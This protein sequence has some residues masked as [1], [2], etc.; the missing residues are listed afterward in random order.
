MTKWNSLT[1]HEQRLM[2]RL[3]GEGSTRNQDP[4]VIAGLRDLGLIEANGLSPSGYDLCKLLELTMVSRRSTTVQAA[5]WQ[6][7]QRT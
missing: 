3:Y 5:R 1:R 6:A 4:M 2:A 7:S